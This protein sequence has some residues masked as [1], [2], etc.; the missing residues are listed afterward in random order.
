ME[1]LGIVVGAVMSAVLVAVAA[2]F[3]LQQRATLQAVRFDD[4]LST[5]HRLYLV[6]RCYRRTFGSLLLLVLE[7]LMIG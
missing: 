6:K 7:G 1:P 5:E 4:T 2:Y 3:A